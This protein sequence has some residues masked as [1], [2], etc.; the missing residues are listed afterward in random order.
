MIKYPYSKLNII[1]S[2]ITEVNSFL[3]NAYLT[4]GKKLQK[5]VFQLKNVI[6]IK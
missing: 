1:K 4:K 2:D 5:I 3:K 6:F